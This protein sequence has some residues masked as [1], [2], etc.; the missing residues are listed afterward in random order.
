[1]YAVLV[2]PAAREAEVGKSPE[3][4]EVEAAVSL[5]CAT[6][7]QPEQQ[8]RCWLKKKFFLNKGMKMSL[9]WGTPCLRYYSQPKN[10]SSG[11]SFSE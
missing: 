2:V 9:L 1:M 7:L 4:G 10:R 11:H 8:R 5:D 3:P 6:V